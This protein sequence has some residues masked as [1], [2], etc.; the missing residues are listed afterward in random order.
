MCQLLQLFLSWEKVIASIR[1]TASSYASVQAVCVLEVRHEM[2]IG[3][4][5]SDKTW[6]DW[7][8]WNHCCLLLAGSNA[9]YVFQI[10]DSHI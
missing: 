6:M 4:L 3:C 10:G 9:G 2:R 1:G 5:V 8:L 7:N